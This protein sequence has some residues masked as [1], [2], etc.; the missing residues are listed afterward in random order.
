MVKVAIIGVG[1]FG[2]NILNA[3]TQA[4]KDG[5]CTLVA[6]CDVS[7]KTLKAQT[8]KYKVKGYADYKEMLDKEDVDG[9]AIATPD[10]FHREP[11]LHAAGLKKHIFVE[12]PMD[13]TVAGCKEMIDAAKKNNVL[14]QVDFHKRYD[15][16]HRE[17][18]KNVRTGKF[19]TIEYGYVHMEDR[20]EVPSVW[21]PSWAPKSSPMWF[22]GIHFIDLMRWILQANG[23]RVYA[24]GKKLK[25]REMGVDTYDSVNAFVE[26]EN[27]T[28]VTF[29]TS[30]I[31]PLKF[32]AVV[33]QGFRLVGTKGVVECDTQDRGTRVCT[34]EKGNETY[35]MGFL[36]EATDRQGK[37]YY[38]GYGIESINDFVYNIDHLKKG[39]SISDLR[40]RAVSA[41]GEDGLEATRIAVAAHESLTTG[42]IINL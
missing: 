33:N 6:I 22:L 2:T 9:V 27:G 42:K 26:F 38:T 21:F 13:L 10:P 29:D 4:Q 32:E 8:G 37:P 15:P 5:V 1:K 39:G 18:C 25:L 24:T 31:I 41:L 36:L 7:E 12:K 30:W 23:R 20:I 14:L 3:F 16:Y 11:V 28:T 17:V 19:G 34:E 35:N 40:K